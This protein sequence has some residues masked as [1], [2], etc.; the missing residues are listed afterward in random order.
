MYDIMCTFSGYNHYSG[1]V[2][3]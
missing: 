3:G 2:S 1:T